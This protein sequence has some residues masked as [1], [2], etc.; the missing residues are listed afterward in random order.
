MILMTFITKL[1]KRFN[2]RFIIVGMIFLILICH[3]IE[4]QKHK[5]VIALLVLFW[6][7]MSRLSRYLAQK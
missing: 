1:R 2:F 3:G 6:I 5:V 7:G 4:W